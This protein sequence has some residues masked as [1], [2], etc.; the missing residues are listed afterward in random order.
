MNAKK[1]KSPK[2]ITKGKES[3]KRKTRTSF[4]SSDDESTSKKFKIDC[5]PFWED[6]EILAGTEGINEVVAKQLVKLYKED[7]TIPFLARY[8][9]D[10]T[11]GL[12]ANQLRNVKVEFD[13]IERLKIKIKNAVETVE[14]LNKLDTH[15]RN[16][17]LG[18]RSIEELDHIFAP[19]KPGAK[20]TLSERAK[21]LGLEEPALMLLEGYAEV[22]L[23]NY[24][25]KQK[26]LGTLADVE[27]G[28]MHIIAGIVATDSEVL[29][30]IRKIR[31]QTFFMIESKKSSAKKDTNSEDDLKFSNYFDYSISSTNIKPHQILAINRGESIKAL[32][33]KII[34]PEFLYRKYS[35]F[36]TSKWIYNKKFDNNRKRIME[37]SIDD[38]YTRL[39]KPHI[40]REVRAQLKSQAEKA[41]Y[42]VFTTNLKQ[43]LLM[44]PI[45]GK[46]ILGIDPGF[47][48][49]CQLAMISESGMV[50]DTADIFPHD[51]RREEAKSIIKNMVKTYGCTLIALG[52]GTACR[53][54][55]CWLSELISGNSFSPLDIVYT[56]VNENGASIYSCSEEARKEFDGLDPKIISA[57]SL[58][59][60]IQE[61]L[62]E[63]VKVEPKHL[64]V[65]MYQHDL[66]KK[67]L[68]RALD[69]VVSEC[70]SFVGVDLNTA[71]QCLLRRIAGLSDR[72]ASSIIGFREHNGLFKSRSQLKNVKGIGT[73][74][75]Q[76]CAGFL[77][78]APPNTNQA[79]EFYTDPLTNKMDCTYIHPE[80]YEEASKVVQHFGL[81]LK[82]VGESDF[83][84]T[85]KLKNQNMNV[86]ELAKIVGSSV[87]SVR[88]IVNALS[89]PLNFDLRNEANSK[90]LF[91]KNVTSVYDLDVGSALSGSISN[92]THFGCFVDVGVGY[93]G[94][95]HSSNMRGYNL[96]IGDKVEVKVINIEINRKR[97]GLEMITK[98]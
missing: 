49:G 58:A 9:K 17:F 68:E 24:I 90:P 64:G 42:D 34:V 70:V 19:F 60:R 91:K 31:S 10:V 48:N 57:V 78:V 65:G 96:E 54:T 22:N 72:R 3:L 18:V 75:F 43:L 79:N 94:L 46:V 40:I 52:N 27:K 66:P 74:V 25:K 59:R 2:T 84:K 35:K 26:E 87:E 80:S 36:C 93:D 23:K 38:A 41:S 30:F 14:K 67:Q 15:L 39:L 13:K 92:C 33:V 83:V 1:R 4:S 62:A 20:K 44:P 8:R 71:S 12:T 56:I 37:M 63:L 5:K 69:E 98:L 16:M 21:A 29:S 28:I 86:T 55:E 76:Q 6:Y 7:N 32:S 95:I 11:G 85:F 73:K 61:P 50:L 45:K 88:L 97:I 47:I 89:Q 81:K 77:R 53:E 82:S 51:K